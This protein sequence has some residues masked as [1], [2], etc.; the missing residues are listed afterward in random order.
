MEMVESS[1]SAGTAEILGDKQETEGGNFNAR[2]SKM[3][4]DSL[5]EEK[6]FPGLIF[7]KLKTKNIKK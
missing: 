3:K 6:V 1:E 5:K 7:Q 4:S 2:K